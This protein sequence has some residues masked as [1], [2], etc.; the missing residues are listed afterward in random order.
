MVNTLFALISH[1]YRQRKTPER[2]KAKI[3]EERKERMQDLPKLTRELRPR[4]R[5]GPK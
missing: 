1:A 5:V 4:R 2:I 3:K